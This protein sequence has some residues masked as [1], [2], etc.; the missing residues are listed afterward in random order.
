VDR[1]YLWIS[2]LGDRELLYRYRDINPQEC[3]EVQPQQ[4]DSM[5]RYTYS[6]LQVTQAMLRM[7]MAGAARKRE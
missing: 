2:K 7:K 6:M 4:A 3:R 1:N 5:K